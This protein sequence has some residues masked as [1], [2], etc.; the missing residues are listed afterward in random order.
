MAF[1]FGNCSCRCCQLNSC[2]RPGGAGGCYGYKGLHLAISGG[3]INC[4]ELN[5]KTQIARAR[6]WQ[7]KEIL[8]VGYKRGKEGR[9]KITGDVDG[10]DARSG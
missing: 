8:W 1:P 10:V 9:E 7:G 3:E 2:S 5:T 4:I 6:F